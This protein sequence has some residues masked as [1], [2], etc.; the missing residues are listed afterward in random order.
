VL[1]IL[2]ILAAIVVIVRPDVAITTVA[3][4]AGIGFL[5]RGVLDISLAM[6]IRRALR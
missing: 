6:A 2:S 5:I 3:I 4:L 1:G